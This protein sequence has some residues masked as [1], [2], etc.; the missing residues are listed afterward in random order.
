MPEGRC[1]ITGG[2][3]SPLRKGV[4]HFPEIESKGGDAD[5][6]KTAVLGTPVSGV[7]GACAVH[8]DHKSVLTVR[9][10]PERSTLID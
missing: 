10:V 3:P 7:S 2:Q 6:E 9:L 5:V 1:Y 4:V 8:T